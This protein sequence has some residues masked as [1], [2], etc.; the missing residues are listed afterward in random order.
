[1]TCEDLIIFRSQSLQV[2]DAVGT[3]EI[4]F[5][6]VKGYHDGDRVK[7]DDWNVPGSVGRIFFQKVKDSR[8]IELDGFVRGTG[9]TLNDRQESWR[10]STDLVKAAMDMS[11]TLATLTLLEPYLGLTDD[12][13]L[14]AVAI[15]IMTG[16]VQSN[17]TYQRWNVQLEAF[18]PAWSVA[19]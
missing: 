13:E 18:D 11:A 9:A 5:D 15:Q 3:P 7:G 14:E 17:M 6:L 16:P 1:M 12:V 8:I 19:S 2:L 4:Y 10:A